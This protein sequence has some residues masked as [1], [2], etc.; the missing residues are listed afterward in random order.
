[1]SWGRRRCRSAG[2]TAVA[3][4]LLRV[5]AIGVVVLHVLVVHIEAVT[6]L[7]VAWEVP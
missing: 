4:I 7:F 3:C 5:G 6:A 2:P 1:M